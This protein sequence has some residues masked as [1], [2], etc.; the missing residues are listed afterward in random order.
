[1]DYGASLENWFPPGT[2]GSN[3]IPCATFT[4]P[5]SETFIE[6]LEKVRGNAPITSKNKKIIITALAKRVSNLWDVEE[7]ER[8][9]HESELSNGR[10]RARL[11]ESGEL[12]DKQHGYINKV[13]VKQGFE[14]LAYSVYGGYF[15]NLYD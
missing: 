2:M 13:G 10:M 9:I 6:F 4:F 3:P 15:I 5:A 11:W 8:Y 7:V 1:M 14:T 12:K